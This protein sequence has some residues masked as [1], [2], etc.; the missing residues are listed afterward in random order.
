MHIGAACPDA[1][2]RQHAVFVR[3]MKRLGAE[4]VEMPF[5]HGA[6]DSIFAKDSGVLRDDGRARRALMARHRYAERE[7]EQTD[8]QRHFLDAGFQVVAA[9]LC[10]LEG[11]D[12]VRSAGIPFALLGYGFRSSRAAARPLERFLCADVITLE[13][14]DPELY[15]L[16]TALAVLDDGAALVCEE[17][18]TP[19]SVRVLRALPFARLYRVPRHEAVEFALNIVEVEKSVLTGSDGIHGGVEVARI[20]RSRGLLPVPVPLSE[21]HRAG[22]SAACLVA[23]VTT[24]VRAQ[25]KC[26][27]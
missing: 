18:F 19:E 12:V 27:A 3:Q 17:A 9:P 23:R 5:V 15:H 20:L 21:F 26:A 22:G 6:Y 14:R 2:A 13:L 11:G 24:D 4:V 7:Q 10:E 25:L 1:S 8:R 16:D